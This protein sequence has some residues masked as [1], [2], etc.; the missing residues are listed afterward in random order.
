MKPE[1]TPFP[2]RRTRTVHVG[3]VPLGS[4]HP[5]AIQSMTTTPTEDVEATVCQVERLARAGASIVRLAVP[6][7]SAAEALRAV[8]V[9]SPVPLVA[10][11]H[12]N[13]RLAVAAIE[14][15]AAK[16]RINPGNTGLGDD[17]A[18]VVEAAQRHA[19]AIR[20][21]VNSGSVMPRTGP[22]ALRRHSPEEIAER[23]V[24]SVLEALAWLG[25]RGFGDV[26]I[27][28]K[29]SDV[30]TTIAAN[31]RVAAMC[32]VPLHLGVTAAGPREEAVL[33]SALGLGA[34]LAEG[35]GDTL[36]VSITGDPVTEVQ[37]GRR[38]LEVLHLAEPSGVEIVSC[39][40]C[41]RCQVDLVPLAERLYAATRDIRVPMQVAVMGCV[42]NGP[43]EAREADLGVAAGRGHGVL[44][45]RGEAVEKVA[46]EAL[47]E[48]LMAEIRR[49]AEGR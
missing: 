11:I 29:A 41:G 13:A 35:V 28:L 45:R 16:V 3:P 6:T 38:M 19:A 47:F 21:G 8:V 10:D 1:D 14:A 44:F 26:V 31:R 4:G 27:S 9:R 30:P 37:V 7:L 12:F 42:V 33:K 18:R 15:G 43:G 46:E 48:R 49:L 36:R 39:P 23:M 5:V 34:L 32:D 24:E 40:T 25:Q 22:E 20:L 2:R 17:L